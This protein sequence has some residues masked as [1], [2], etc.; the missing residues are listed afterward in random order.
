MKSFSIFAVLLFALTARA[1]T[2]AFS[3][4]ELDLAN[5]TEAQTPAAAQIQQ[6]AQPATYSEYFYLPAR[7]E[8]SAELEY[9][10]INQ[11]NTSRA[12]AL[13]MSGTVV[14]QSTEFHGTEVGLNITRSIEKTYY[15][16]LGAENRADN[17]QRFQL[18][19]T[20]LAPIADGNLVLGARMA[21]FVSAQLNGDKF[22]Q[23]ELIPFIGFEQ[24][25]HGAA[26]G[27][28][29]SVDQYLVRQTKASVAGN[30]FYEMPAVSK[31]IIGAKT[32]L[33][34]MH[35]G[36]QTGYQAGLYS[37]YSPV[38]NTD[39]RLAVDTDTAHG[40]SAEG[41]TQKG[42]TVSVGFRRTL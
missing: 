24:R 22:D 10:S 15:L 9:S 41:E 40:T 35:V 38:Q 27:I 42:T 3:I 26:W 19:L 37:K 18:G 2:Q 8:T 1:E 14:D 32:G 34:Q 5:R 13:D 29:T 17:Y 4:G 16:S 6:P 20:K 30:V 11:T 28:D 21:T 33:N 25:S 12:Y 39:I 7:G 23:Y 36:Q 31:V